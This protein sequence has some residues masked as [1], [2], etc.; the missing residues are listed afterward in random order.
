MHPRNFIT[1]GE[2]GMV[3][4]NDVALAK[5]MSTYKHFG[6]GEHGARLETHFQQIGTNYK[7]SDVLSAIGLEQMKCIDM[8]LEQ[9][10]TLSF[11]YIE[12][13]E[14]IE[15]VQLP[16]TTLKGKHAYQSFCV[17]VKNRNEVMKQLRSNGIEVQIG[18]YALHMQKSFKTNTGCRIEGNMK[19]SRYLF[20][21]VLTLPLFHDLGHADQQMIIRM[22]SEII[23]SDNQ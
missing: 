20:D 4:T 10:R 14:P 11:Q 3:T 13:I 15:H 9:R 8:L 6:M 1:S 17:F 22:L 12:M 16:M 2:G 18:T 21:H 23:D 7:L 5:K 19:K